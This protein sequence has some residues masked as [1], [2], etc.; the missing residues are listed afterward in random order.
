MLYTVT[1]GST[2]LFDAIGLRLKLIRGAHNRRHVLLILSY[3]GDNHSL[4]SENATKKFVREADCQIYALGIFANLSDPTLRREEREGPKVLTDIAKMS[5]GRM[6]P[7]TKTD[8]RESLQEGAAKQRGSCNEV[9][10]TGRDSRPGG[11]LPAT[12]RWSSEGTGIGMAAILKLLIARR[13]YAP[14]FW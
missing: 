14:T 2:A 8:V 5:G 3:G 11:H 7:V 6:F 10:A 9:C 1:K 4:H 12:T 13:Y